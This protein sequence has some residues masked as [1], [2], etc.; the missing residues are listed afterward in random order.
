MATDCTIGDPVGAGKTREATEPI[1][2]NFDGTAWQFGQ[3]LLKERAAA[4]R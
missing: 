2:L 1:H 4:A 3:P